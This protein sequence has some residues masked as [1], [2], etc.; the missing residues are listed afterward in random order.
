MH[1]IF[2][3]LLISSFIFCAGSAA[4]NCDNFKQK[5]ERLDQQKRAGGSAKQ[6]ARLQIRRNQLEDAYNNCR[7][8]NND[9]SRIK[10]ASGKA[11]SVKPPK[12]KHL[13]LKSD[14]PLTQ[15]RIN[16]CNYWVD[17]YNASPSDTHKSF[18]DS[19]C[20]A[21]QEAENTGLYD[22]PD[23]PFIAIRKFHECAKPSG[24]IDNDVALC[25]EGKMQ[26]YWI[27]P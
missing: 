14:N 5:I 21:A 16:T 3:A 17:V 25:M 10:F 7:R 22:E 9:E 4:A 18:K 6:M 2:N 20:S 13:T 12:A 24:L 26:P 23:A 8:N 11:A 15:Q 27:K 19:A 1:Y